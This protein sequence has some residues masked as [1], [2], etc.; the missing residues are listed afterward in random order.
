MRLLIIEDEKNLAELLGSLLKK[1][2]FAVD[3]ANDGEKGSFLARTQAYDLIITDYVLPKLDGGSII[4]EIRDDGRNVPIIMLSVRQSIIDKIN[5][6]DIG[7][8]DYLSKPFSGEEL[9]ARI[10]ALLR[11]PQTVKE[12]K[13]VFADLELEPKSFKVKRGGKDIRLTNKEFSLLQHLLLNAGK[14]VSRESLLEHV[15]SGDIDPFSNTVETH[16]LRLR[17]KI[18]THRPKLIHSII[19]RGYKL[20]KSA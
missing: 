9:L 3:I 13:L 16:I 15:W 10:R 17:R 8:D 11:R 20:D 5:I 19:G 1:A 7:A 18:D 14:I 6:L 2:G 12:E 4:K